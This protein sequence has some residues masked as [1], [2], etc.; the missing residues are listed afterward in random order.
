MDYVNI[1]RRV[2]AVQFKGTN[3]E[4]IAY[5]LGPLIQSYTNGKDDQ[6]LYVHLNSDRIQATPV[7]KNSW[8]VISDTEKTRIM[9][10][11]DFEY[12]YK[13]ADTTGNQSNT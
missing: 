1:Q 13:P 9:S 10:N 4:E 6:D 3:I 5:V 11:E 12:L 2:T 8:V 7:P